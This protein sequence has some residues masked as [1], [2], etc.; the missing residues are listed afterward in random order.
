[1]L[2]LAAIEI[3]FVLLSLA[4][5][6]VSVLAALRRKKVEA[7]SRLDN[8]REPTHTMQSSGLLRSSSISSH[9]AAGSGSTAAQSVGLGRG[10]LPSASVVYTGGQVGYSRSCVLTS[11]PCLESCILSTL[12]DCL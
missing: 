3:A 11:N 6:S 8:S 4:G 1:V 5:V 12:T 10:P 7:V 2:R 9:F